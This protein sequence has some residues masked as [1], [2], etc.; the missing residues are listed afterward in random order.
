[1]MTWSTEQYPPRMRGT[2]AGCASGFGRLA[3]MGAPLVLG[4][5]LEPAHGGRATA[6]LPFTVLLISAAASIGLF[7]Q[8]TAGRTLEELSR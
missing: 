4:V 5:L 2:A 8:E 3:A 7:A 1:M 6:M